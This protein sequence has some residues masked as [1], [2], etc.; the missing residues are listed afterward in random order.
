M[1]QSNLYKRE[2][3]TQTFNLSS[4]D[5]RDLGDV[6]VK[7]WTA[8][9]LDIT[10]DGTRILGEVQVTNA[11]GQPSFNTLANG[12]DSCSQGTPAALNGGTTINLPN[13]VGV[14]VAALNGNSNP[15]YV[16]DGSVTTGDGYELSPGEQLPHPLMVDD[17]ADIHVEGPDTASVSW[18]VEVN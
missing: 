1:A 2:T 15:I 5:A 16:G 13:G 17:V 4:N 9:A 12:Q 14:R 10:D 18:V 7:E 6:D 8:G 3:G 11:V